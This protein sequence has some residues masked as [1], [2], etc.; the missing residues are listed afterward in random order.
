VCPGA[1]DAHLHRMQMGIFSFNSSIMSS[2]R[3]EWDGTH[4]SPQ[5]VEVFT[6][7]I[8]MH[9]KAHLSCAVCLLF[10][11]CQEINFNLDGLAVI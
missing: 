3:E 2:R 1:E 5:P 9:K 4:Y 7:A 6:E 8:Y 11:L 10:P